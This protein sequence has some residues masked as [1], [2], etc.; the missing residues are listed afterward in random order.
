MNKIEQL[1]RARKLSPQEIAK[2]V[3]ALKKQLLE[4]SQQKAL[5]KLKNYRSIRELRREIA[6]YNTIMD[7]KIVSQLNQKQ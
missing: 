4:A 2:H 6:R 7:E 1:N 3:V 5:G